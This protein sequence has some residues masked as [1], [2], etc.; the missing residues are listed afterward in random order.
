ML[1]MLMGISERGLQRNIH[2]TVKTAPGLLHPL[3]G[4]LGEVVKK[5]WAL[6]CP[7][8]KGLRSAIVL[9]L[10]SKVVHLE[11]STSGTEHLN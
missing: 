4:A 10:T 1:M 6:I 5:K 11:W 8:S 9:A 7:T 3:Q 2:G